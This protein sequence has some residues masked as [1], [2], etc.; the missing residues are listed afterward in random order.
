[1]ATTEERL[2][3]LETQ[4]AKLTA[5]TPTD[6]YMHAYSG[7]EID[8]AVGRSLPGGEIDNL[9]PGVNLLDNPNFDVWQRGESI[10]TT[11]LNT[12][13]ADRW[14]ISQIGFTVTKQTDDDGNP[15]IRLV[16]TSQAAEQCYF[17]QKFESP[18]RFA[19]KA[20]TA[21][22]MLRGYNGFQNAIYV[23]PGDGGG[24]GAKLTEEW[25]VIKRTNTFSYDT[26]RAL[27]QGVVIYTTS[28]GLVDPGQGIDIKFVKAELGSVS[29]MAH[30][31]EDGNW[32]L[33]DPPP[34]KALELAK[35]QRYQVVIPTMDVIGC[36][37]NTTTLYCT[38]PTPTTM[39]TDR[40]SITNNGVFTVRDPD[41]VQS[42]LTASIY[43]T[44]FLPNGIR[45][46]IAGT[47]VANKAYHVGINSKIILD[48]NL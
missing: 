46:G 35:C 27:T 9:R 47:F 17:F 34:N 20:V 8:E 23:R 32:V 21:A 15:F 30:Q 26:S 18:A 5:T 22:C 39:R 25:D 42:G 33:N 13:C 24:S 40:I 6:Y 31:D 1:M 2:A 7:E 4:L 45:V 10:V 16:N 43:G 28:T 12:Y 37:N 19:G 14:V 3:A 29:T 36:T 41:G 48:A 38:I 11:A 44:S